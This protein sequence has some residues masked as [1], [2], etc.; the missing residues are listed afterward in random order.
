MHYLPQYCP[1]QKPIELLFGAIKR[2]LKS[3]I[4]C[5]GWN[6]NTSEG[7]E[8]I[9]DI[10]TKIQKESVINI[11]GDYQRSQAYYHRVSVA[12]KSYQMQ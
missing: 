3:K 11:A 5:K 7:K 1:K 6:F 4:D 12:L 2:K 8:D 9:V 10:L